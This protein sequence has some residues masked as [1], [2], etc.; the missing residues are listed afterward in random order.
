MHAEINTYTGSDQ[1]L[2]NGKRVM[3]RDIGG[4]SSL[5]TQLTRLSAPQAS[6]HS[7][8]ESGDEADNLAAIQYSI[9][10]C[11]SRVEVL[12]KCKQ[13]IYMC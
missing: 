9:G 2:W 10:T 11:T 4:I 1:G 13:L 6:L 3:Q 7:T 12:Y 5:H 8:I